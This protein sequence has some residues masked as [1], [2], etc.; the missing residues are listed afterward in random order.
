MIDVNCLA[1]AALA[2]HFGNRFAKA[3]R[4]GLVL[5]SS[6]LA[7]QGVPGAANYAATKAYV[8][9]LAEGCDWSCRRSGSTSSRRLQA[10]FAAAL[11]DAPT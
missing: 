6:L 3:G 11:P 4:G 9:S 5:M 10:P 2:H 8:Q 1:V 7:F